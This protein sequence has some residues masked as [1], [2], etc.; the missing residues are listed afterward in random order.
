MSLRYLLLYNS[1]SA[2]ILLRENLGLTVGP[3]K[4]EK[5]IMHS[6]PSPYDVTWAFVAHIS[7]P[8]RYHHELNLIMKNTRSFMPVLSNKN[9]QDWC[10]RSAN[11]R[12]LWTSLGNCKVIISEKN[13]QEWLKRACRPKKPQNSTNCCLVQES[14]Y[15]CGLGKLE[16][17]WPRRRFTALS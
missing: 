3:E 10:R 7:H 5:K 1:C 17:I 13:R 8:L 12:F 2:F 6:Y 11:K 4:S 9:Y 15:G 16:K 14:Y